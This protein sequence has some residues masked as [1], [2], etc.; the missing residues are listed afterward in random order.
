MPALCV[1]ALRL[2]IAKGVI[3]TPYDWINKFYSLYM[4]AVV[5]IVSRHGLSINA[6]GRNQ[7]N[8]S[9]LVLYNLL[10]SLEESF[11]TVVHK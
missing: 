6:H 3:W 2:L 4:A 8:K 9:K 1:S 5:G 7:P 11:N 10:L